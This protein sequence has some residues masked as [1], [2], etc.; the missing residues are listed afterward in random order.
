MK[1]KIIIMIVVV[2]IDIIIITID[3][4]SDEGRHI[5]DDIMYYYLTKPSAE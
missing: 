2:V 5:K 1:I 4:R 3:I